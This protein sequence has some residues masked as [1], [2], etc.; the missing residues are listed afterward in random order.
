MAT[1]Y[2]LDTT[3]SKSVTNE[4]STYKQTATV[5]V[6]ITAAG[7]VSWKITMNNDNDGSR[8]RAVYLEVKLG[9]QTLQKAGYTCYYKADGKTVDEDTIKWTT[10][11]T[12]NG[13]SKSGS[14]T[15]SASSLKLSVTICCMRNSSNSE[16]A[17]V[18]NHTI[19]RNKWTD[20]TAGDITGITDLGKNTFRIS[21]KLGTNGTG[22]AIKS[23]T[24]YYTFDGSQPNKAA[25]PRVAFTVPKDKISSGRTFSYTFNVPNADTNKTYD[26]RAVVSS[27]FTY[28]TDGATT[29]TSRNDTEGSRNK[30]V[31]YRYG[32]NPSTPVISYSKNRLTLKENISFTWTDGEATTESLPLNCLTGYRIRLHSCTDADL[33][34]AEKANKSYLSLGYNDRKYLTEDHVYKYSNGID[35]YYQTFDAETDAGKQLVSGA[36]YSKSAPDKKGI[37]THTLTFDPNAFGFSAGEYVYLTIYARYAYENAAETTL[38]YWNGSK[39]GVIVYSDLIKFQNAGIVHVKVADKWR[40]GQVWVK[41]GDRWREAENVQ[42]KVG[43]TWRESQ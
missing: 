5:D 13:S 37:V 16:V 21:G 15:T 24:I 2:F 30:N 27:T 40:E 43:G 11:P 25:S 18:F 4:Y 7:K 35:A 8:G 20:G 38:T 32:A 31:K 26:V 19:E 39:D 12:G 3:Y 23:A 14:F 28:G 17:T 1:N 9:D 34:A 42:T 33:E 6:S 29:K 41:V 10:Y 22:N 36:S